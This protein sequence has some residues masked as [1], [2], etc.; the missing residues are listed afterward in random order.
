[1]DSSRSSGEF[2]AG[3]NPGRAALGVGRP[4]LERAAGH[5]WGSAE[6]EVQ[7]HGPAPGAPHGPLVGPS[8]VATGSGGQLVAM[9]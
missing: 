7:A 3:E 8:G 6:L 1:M 9:L 4:V 2:K 5:T